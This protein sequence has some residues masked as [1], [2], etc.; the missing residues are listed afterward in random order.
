MP[1]RAKQSLENE[2]PSILRML[3]LA[4]LVSYGL[5]ALI[6]TWQIVSSDFR[7]EGY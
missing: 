5:F 7:L 3:T 1:V 4:S 6:V 2:L